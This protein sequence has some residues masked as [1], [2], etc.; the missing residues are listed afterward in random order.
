MPDVV[1]RPPPVPEPRSTCLHNTP[2][3]V[4]VW[5]KYPW[6]WMCTVCHPQLSERK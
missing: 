5:R 1:K 6:G 3:P 4:A 2:C